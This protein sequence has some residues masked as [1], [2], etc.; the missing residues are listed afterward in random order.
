MKMS[1]TF[2]GLSFLLLTILF[3]RSLAKVSAESFNLQVLINELSPIDSE[4]DWAELYVESG[5]GNI[6]NFR[7]T[8]LDGTD[9]QLASQP[10]TVKAGDFVLV[11]WDSNVDETDLVGDLNM[12]GYLDLYLSDSPLSGTDDQL[13]LMNDEEILDAVVW[14]NYDGVI[15][16]SELQDNEDL[17][18]SNDWSGV[19]A[20][21]DQS[22][23]VALAAMDQSLARLETDDTNTKDDWHVLETP[24]PGEVNLTYEAPFK[25]ELFAEEIGT[26]SAL[27]T[28]NALEN[29]QYY[30][31]YESLLSGN[32][33]LPLGEIE[34]NIHSYQL[35][36]LDSDESYYYKL[37]AFG[38]HDLY[39]DS[40]ELELQTEAVNDSPFT[41]LDAPS[42]AYL[43][44]EVVLDASDS[45]DPEDEPLIF[46]WQE[47]PTNPMLNILETDNDQAVFRASVVGDYSFTLMVSDGELFGDE[48]EIT[49]EILESELNN[50]S[51]QIVINEILA[52]PI[53][54][55]LEDEFVELKNIGD[56]S[57]N[58]E[59]WQLDDVLEAG[60][61]P[62][63]FSVESIQA[64]D[65]LVVKRSESQLALNNDKDTINLTAP[66]GEVKDSVSYNE[67]SEG[68]SYARTENG[69]FEVTTILTEGSENEFDED[70]VLEEKIESFLE[71]ESLDL[72]KDF[73]EE[74]SLAEAKKTLTE[75]I[76]FEATVSTTWGVLGSNLIYL[77]SGTEAIQAYSSS[78]IKASLGDKLIFTGEMIGLQNGLRFRI[79]SWE[80][81]YETEELVPLKLL[82]S[83]FA[84]DYLGR[85]IEVSG[86]V[87]RNSGQTFYLLDEQGEIKL[88][89]KDSAGF[90][91]PEIARESY[92]NV[93]GILD[94]TS[95]GYRVLPRSLED[96]MFDDGSVPAPNK[97]V[98]TGMQHLGLYAAV[99]LLVTVIRR[100]LFGL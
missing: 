26:S 37:R 4:H 69:E 98:S 87:N 56:E 39:T 81:K 93:L 46:T 54:S 17:L 90:S 85:L 70:E 29:I 11:H 23:A 16:N 51:D 73:C 6:A 28:W 72:T 3:W 92:L 34:A 7:L 66:N 18:L 36:D 15:A 50:Y 61:R 78:E 35:E 65:F 71:K 79:E 84:D 53:G 38:E 94:K 77:Q 31:L 20:E 44:E 100:K 19:F 63:T 40:D 47:K 55:D 9:S 8:D 43:G 14:S 99:V 45:F 22:G 49:V 33:D 2:L 30:E 96:F 95:S 68:K 1:H 60:S 32:Y 57:V 48:Q 10:V 89:I 86:T 82:S 67:L 25:P 80:E 13:V 62:Y 41:Y 42:S 83:E 76:C 75:T 74:I 88:T 97:L 52:N 64:D 91:K 59:N 21:N 58:L 27:L 12:N 24:T 5:S